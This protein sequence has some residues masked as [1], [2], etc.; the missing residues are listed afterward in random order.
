MN[1]GTGEAHYGG[2]ESYDVLKW[3]GQQNSDPTFHVD[4]IIDS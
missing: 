1:G 2:G 3:I 4:T